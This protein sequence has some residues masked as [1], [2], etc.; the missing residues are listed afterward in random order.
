M[1]EVQ[2][3]TKGADEVFCSSCGAVIKMQ[4]EI[5]PKCGVRQKPAARSSNWFTLFLLSLIV[6]GFGVDRFYVGKVGTGVLKMIL[7]CISLVM[8]ITL[9]GVMIGVQNGDMVITDKGA[10]NALNIITNILMGGWSIW[11]LVDFIMVCLG[12]F[13]DSKGNAIKRNS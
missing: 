2:N 10:L 3:G 6:G 5:C 12:K 4:A 7:G 1:S 11:W 9:A 8:G 13:T